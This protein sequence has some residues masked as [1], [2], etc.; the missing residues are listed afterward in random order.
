M[1]WQLESR[2]FKNPSI[3]GGEFTFTNT[4]KE[5]RSFLITLQSGDGGLS[6]D[7]LESGR[8][9][10]WRAGVRGN[11]IQ[12]YIN[13]V[14][15]ESINGGD[16]STQKFIESQYIYRWGSRKCGRHWWRGVKWCNDVPMWGWKNLSVKKN[17]AS[18]SSTKSFI[19][20]LKQ[21]QTLKFKF[22]GNGSIFG[23]KFNGLATMSELPLYQNNL[24]DYKFWLP[25]DISTHNGRTIT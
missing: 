22:I 12:V 11:E 18:S 20:N 23:T 10:Y 14:L 15:Q 1:S 4:R 9:R 19:I 5:T 16:P 21:N 6:P 13:N 3:N 25:Q 24:N 2:T 8:D 17:R 7:Y